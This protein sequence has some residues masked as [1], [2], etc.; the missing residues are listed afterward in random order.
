VSGPARPAWNRRADLSQHFLRD[1][2]ARR[3]IRCT[4]ISKSDLIV[5]IGPGRGAL[6]RPLV[7]RAGRL[8]AVEV[9]GYLARQLRRTLAGRVEVVESDFLEFDLPREPFRVI[10]NIPY[11]QSTAIVRKLTES[12]HS[13]VDAWLVVQ[14]EFAMRLC[15]RPFGKESPW[16]LALEPFWH[17]EIVDGVDR[18]EFT[19]PPAVASAFLHLARRARPLIHPEE[20]AGFDRLLALGF[21]R[22]TLRQSLKPLLSKVQMRR[23]AADYCFDVSDS[24]GGLMF[25]QW[26]GIFRFVQRHGG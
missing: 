26:L 21:A 22:P 24:P 7:E 1:E 18:R 12:P 14:R 16:S 19:P 17:L 9:D 11:A 3:L 4:P 10:G 13:P 6:T 8:I 15:G 2:S 5:E 25:D 23:L 20:A